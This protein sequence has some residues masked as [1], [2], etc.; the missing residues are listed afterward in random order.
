MENNEE[1]YKT[2]R[3]KK[4]T[5]EVKG[6]KTFAFEDGHDIHYKAGQYLTFIK[7][8]G[9]RKSGGLIL[10]HPLLF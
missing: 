8:L 7:L 6:F 4:I 2:L 9:I 1:I 3:I 5:E 10:S